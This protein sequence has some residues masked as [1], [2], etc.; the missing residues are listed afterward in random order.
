VRYNPLDRFPAA[1]RD[2]SALVP[3][4]VMWGE[5]ETA[6]RELGIPEIASVRIFDTYK[7]KDMP[8]G[9]HSLA[10]RV[11]Y[12]GK[13]RTLTDE[14]LTDMHDRIRMLLEKGFGAQLR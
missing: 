5:I 3:D 11:T 7:G 13:G 6:V 9:F 8:D 14:E 10:F 1:S 12:R 4:T 2:V